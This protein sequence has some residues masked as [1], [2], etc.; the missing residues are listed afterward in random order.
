MQCNLTWNESICFNML[1]TGDWTSFD[2]LEFGEGTSF[3]VL[4]VVL[5][6][7]RDSLQS[8]IVIVSNWRISAARKSYSVNTSIL[9]GNIPVDLNPDSP[10]LINATLLNAL[11]TKDA[12]S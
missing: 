3:D 6:L 5:V 2:V 4:G 12:T 1:G 11:C 9:S 8:W 7:G 10:L